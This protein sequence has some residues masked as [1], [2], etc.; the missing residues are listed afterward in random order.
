MRI[1]KIREKSEMPGLN[2]AEASFIRLIDKLTNGTR[3][4]I[5]DT[6]TSVRLIPGFIQGGIVQHDCGL[7]R[8]IGYF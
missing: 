4:E 2:E 5:S 1:S 8:G 3:I 7:D 6:G